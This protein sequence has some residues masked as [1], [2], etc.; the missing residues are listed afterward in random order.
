MSMSNAERD[1]ALAEIET[2]YRQFVEVLDGLSVED[3]E[4]P[5]TVGHWSGK[6]LLSHLAAWNV[7]ASRHILAR[8]SGAD[9]SMPAESE[10]D[11]WNER[12]IAKTRDWTVD[13]VRSYFDRAHQD[14][15]QTVQGSPT[16][17]SRFATGMSR[18]HY[19]E[20]IDQ[21]GGMKSPAS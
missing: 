8:D 15:V 2:G 10:F 12:E 7:E 6:D 16:V 5:G 17:T 13:Q 19:G 18:D 9:D 11:E 21:F 20:H 4:R 3:M 1:V 14:F